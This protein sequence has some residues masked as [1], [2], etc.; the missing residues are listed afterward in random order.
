LAQFYVI[1]VGAK[2]SL[3]EKRLLA[4]FE[5]PHGFMLIGHIGLE[6][7]HTTS[8][9]YNGVLLLTLRLKKLFVSR[10]EFYRNSLQKSN[11]RTKHRPKKECREFYRHLLFP[12]HNISGVRTIGLTISFSTIRNILKVNLM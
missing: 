9:V 5:C 11:S 8:P 1:E 2:T 6:Y 3:A 12:F 7:A 4:I 10:F